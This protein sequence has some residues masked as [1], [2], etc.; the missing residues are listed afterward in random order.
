VRNQSRT[1]GCAQSR[2]GEEIIGDET[3]FMEELMASISC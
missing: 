1:T 2:A 3:L